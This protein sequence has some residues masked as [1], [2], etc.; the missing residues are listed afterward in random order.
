LRKTR[1]LALPIRTLIDIV[2]GPLLPEI[3]VCAIIK[4]FRWF[5][6]IASIP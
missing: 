1:K 4:A 3:V 5:D 2:I 6:I